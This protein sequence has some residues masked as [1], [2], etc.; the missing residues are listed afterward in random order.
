MK[1]Q[2]LKFIREKEYRFVREIG[3][4]GLGRTVLLRDDL[5]N[6]VFICKKYAPITGVDRKTYFKNFVDEIKL[7]HLLYHK[8]VVRV[9]NYFLY[10]EE[11]TG[12][13]F[14][15]YVDGMDIREFVKKNPDKLVDVFVQTISGFDY[16]QKVG[17]LHRDIRPSNILVSK[18][19]FVKI[20]DF[21]FGKKIEF[22]IDFDK[23]ITLNWWYSPPDE[24]KN[25]VYDYKSEIYFIGRLFEDMI[26][27]ND[28]QSFPYLSILKRMTSGYKDR[29]DSFFSITREI[30]TDRDSGDLFL[31]EERQ[32]YRN[33][34]T[35]LLQALDCFFEDAEYISDVSSVVQ[36]LENLYRSS[37]LEDFVQS[38]S[39]LV[40][41][42]VKGGFVSNT[43]EIM[44]VETLRTFHNLIKGI[45]VDKQKI[46]LNHIWLR[47]DGVG[48]Y[49]SK[50][51]SDE[52]PF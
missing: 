43:A 33:F 7:L 20:I 14:M 27:E 37:M 35:T 21:G 11:M 29:I 23:S 24:F 25:K 51:Y 19:G 32:V 6:E 39:S 16:L 30:L 42:F 38:N 49:S 50:S 8:N 41:C 52:L 40:Q 47:F 44:S 26:Q 2:I 48:R 12:Y 18:D 1:D 45:S 10:P 4:G 28:I 22:T 31:K 3:Q 13:I 36:K 15:E 17:I 9:F 5:I 46:L 34:A